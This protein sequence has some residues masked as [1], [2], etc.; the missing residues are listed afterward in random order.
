MCLSFKFSGDAVLL[1]EAQEPQ[2]ENH[3]SRAAMTLCRNLN[4]LRLG[5][6]PGICSFNLAA[7]HFYAGARWVTLKC[8]Y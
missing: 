8:T 6:G 7:G 3:C 5:W 1:V 4:S 2:A